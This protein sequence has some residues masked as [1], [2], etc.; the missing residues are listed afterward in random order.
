MAFSITTYR[1]IALLLFVAYIAA[2]YAYAQSVA[3]FS[4]RWAAKANFKTKI[5]SK[6]ASD[7]SWD[8]PTWG[9]IEPSGHLLIVAD[10]GCI[11]EGNLTKTPLSGAMW[12]A[13]SVKVH[14]CEVAEMNREY[15]ANAQIPRGKTDMVLSFDTSINSKTNFQP[16]DFY[17]I[18]GVFA[19][20]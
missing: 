13:G 20:Y 11:I 4:G 2:G 5:S 6:Q 3:A 7:Y 10:N 15:V 8:G 14:S 18:K 16:A 19:R 9:F 17:Q 12:V 1:R